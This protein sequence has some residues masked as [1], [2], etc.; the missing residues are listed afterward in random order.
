MARIRNYPGYPS[1]AYGVQ[2]RQARAGVQRAAR[3]DLIAEQRMRSRPVVRGVTRTAGFYGRYSGSTPELKFFDTALSFQADATA[4][5]PA[6][7]QLALIPQGVTQSTRVGRKASVKSINV[8]GVMQLTPTTDAIATEV[9][10]LYLMQDTQCNGAAATVSGDT[11]IFTNANLAQANMNL[12]NGQ[13]FKILKK[14]VM[15]FTAQAG[16]S[17]AYNA[18]IKPFN[19]YKKRNIPLEYDAAAATGV[20]TTIRSNNIFLVCGTAGSADDRVA[21]AGTCRLRFSD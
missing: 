12:S 7:G 10:Y 15:A 18:V 20:I 3:L 5:V 16:V 8:H 14:W 17:A 1:T 6:T 13:R 19:F 4:E 11:G 9:V 2:R 21:V